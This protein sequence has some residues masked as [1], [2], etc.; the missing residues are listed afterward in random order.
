MSKAL[1]LANFE[2]DM[3]Q[4]K[5]NLKKVKQN[6]I[7]QPDELRNLV[8]SLA[9]EHGLALPDVR[10]PA[11]EVDYN[12]LISLFASSVGDSYT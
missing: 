7:L 1:H 3:H 12:L 2:A 4:H 6:E 10:D 9:D 5:I 11:Y 8:R